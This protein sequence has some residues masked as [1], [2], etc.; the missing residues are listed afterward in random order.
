METKF[1]KHVESEQDLINRACKL[2]EVLELDRLENKNLRLEVEAEYKSLLDT[3]KA[4]EKN[5]NSNELTQDEIIDK[6]LPFDFEL[7]KSGRWL[8]IFGNTRP[9]RD[10]LKKL[11]LRFSP[12]KKCWYWRPDKYRSLNKDPKELEEIFKIYGRQK[13]TTIK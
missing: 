2:K 5:S 11:K 9:H 4:S 8:W 3:F 12:G 1:F 7:I 10:F 13:V 6:L